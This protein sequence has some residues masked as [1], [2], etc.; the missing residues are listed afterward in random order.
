M[1]SG[2]ASLVPASFSRLLFSSTLSPAKSRAEV[3]FSTYL[4]PGPL[5][6]VATSCSEENE[7]EN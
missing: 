7:E 2:E 5:L 1:F 6:W 4:L 3:S